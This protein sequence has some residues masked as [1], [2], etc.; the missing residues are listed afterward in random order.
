[1][2]TKTLLSILLSGCFAV[3]GAHAQTA[4][5][6]GNSDGPPAAGEASNMTN[7]V[8]NAKT[9]NS[10]FTEKPLPGQPFTAVIIDQSDASRATMAMGAPAAIY[11]D[12]ANLR[13]ARGYGP[14]EPA[15]PVPNSPSVFEGGTPQ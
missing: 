2:K 9:T 5:A 12:P 6:T 8:P 13:G 10:P 3:A 4:P 14:G 11:V 1:M 7:G 15:N